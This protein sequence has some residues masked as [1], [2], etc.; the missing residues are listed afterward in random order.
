MKQVVQDFQSFIKMNESEKIKISFRSRN[1]INEAKNLEDSEKYDIY[2]FEH[3][4]VE[5]L[6]EGE[7][8]NIIESV[9]QATDDVIST[10]GLG[11][12]S[13]IKDK[14]ENASFLAQD[15]IAEWICKTTLWYKYGLIL[16]SKEV[17]EFKSL[18]FETL[19]DRYADMAKTDLEED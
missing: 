14:E 10:M 1:K 17:S 2:N 7:Y 4:K 18:F 9:L 3:S 16:D 8:E 6:D 11:E 12:Y 5:D 15:S 13:V 19:E